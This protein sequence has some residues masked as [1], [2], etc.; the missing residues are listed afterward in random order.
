MREATHVAYRLKRA[1]ERRN[2]LDH[3]FYRAWTAGTLTGED[4]AFYSTQYWRQVEAF[5]GYLASIASRL[6]E[7]RVREIVN[8]NLSDE[9]DGDH[10][11]LW[12]RFAQTVGAAPGRVRSAAREPETSVCVESFERAAIAAPL[13]YA[14]GMLF[15]YESQTPEVSATKVAGLR[16]RYG[17]DGEGVEYFE[18]HGKL[19]VEHTAQLAEA[20]AEICD[21]EE[22][23]A[24]AEEGAREGAEAVWILLDGVARVRQITC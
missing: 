20:I 16:E 3:P 24:L 13:P 23:L 10:P 8:E 1:T 4:L 22:D 17:I 9:R 14:L 11:G 21:D 2:L 5:P 19:D 18:L 12:L 7:G 15:G 6:P